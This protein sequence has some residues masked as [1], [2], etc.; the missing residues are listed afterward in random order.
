[1]KVVVAVLC[2]DAGVTTSSNR[3]SS[4]LAVTRTSERAT[5]RS[6]EVIDLV[7]LPAGTRPTPIAYLDYD[8]VSTRREMDCEYYQACLSFAAR[9]RWKSFHCRQCPKHPDRA[10]STR[11]LDPLVDRL[12]D[13][14]VIKL[15]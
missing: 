14:V 15:P 11:R 9:V 10:L 2:S 3:G 7:Q 6:A 8:E 4:T 13:A 1:M 12:S 5:E